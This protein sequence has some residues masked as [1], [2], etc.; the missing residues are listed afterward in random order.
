MSE[1]AHLQKEALSENFALHF[2]AL[3][4]ERDFGHNQRISR[5]RTQ[6][7]T[8][9]RKISVTHFHKT[10]W[11]GCIVGDTLKRASQCQEHYS[12]I[13]QLLAGTMCCHCSRAITNYE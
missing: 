3:T 6:D 13:H 8:L 9:V 2:S 4:E 10:I 12:M 7:E 1:I 5:N 11:F